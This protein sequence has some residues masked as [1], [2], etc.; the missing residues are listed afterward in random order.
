MLLRRY[1]S[2]DVSATFCFGA[3]CIRKQQYLQKQWIQDYCHRATCYA[4]QLLSNLVKCSIRFDTLCGPA[5]DDG[6]IDVWQ[7][8]HTCPNTDAITRRSNR[9]SG[10]DYDAT[11]LN[12]NFLKFDPE[13]IL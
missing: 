13:K 3:E 6:Q 12:S 9:L 10:E 1:R 8:N 11:P 4:L 2:G 7:D 5:D